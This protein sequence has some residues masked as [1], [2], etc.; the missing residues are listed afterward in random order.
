[1]ARR[2]TPLVSRAEK[3][4]YQ[5]LVNEAFGAAGTDVA[6]GLQKFFSR[7][8]ITRLGGDLDF[9]INAKPSLLT[10]DQWLGV[11]R[12]YALQQ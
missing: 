7:T 1:M 12:Y 6:A 4:L 11:F 9:H 8:Q 5:R 3:R 10:F 2:E